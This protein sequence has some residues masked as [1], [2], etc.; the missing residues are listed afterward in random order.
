MAQ[1]DDHTKRG[2][3]TAYSNTG[4]YNALDFAMEQKLR[5]GLTTSFVGRVDA[6]SGKGSDDGSGSVSATQLTAQA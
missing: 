3:D 2:L 1:S 6:C 5:N 4:A